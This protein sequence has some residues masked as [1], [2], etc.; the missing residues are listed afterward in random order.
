MEQVFSNMPFSNVFLD[1]I[2][3]KAKII[4]V[5]VKNARIVLNIPFEPD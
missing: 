1:D 2:I 3:V 5:I 4:A